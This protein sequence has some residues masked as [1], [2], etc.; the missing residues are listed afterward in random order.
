[1]ANPLHIRIS[2]KVLFHLHEAK[3]LAVLLSDVFEKSSP[4]GRL[5]LSARKRI[6]L[7]IKRIENFKD[8]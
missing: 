7:A 4:R 1:M 6:S 3:D 8:F 5:L 2:N